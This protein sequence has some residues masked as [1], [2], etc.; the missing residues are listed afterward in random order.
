MGEGTAACAK[1]LGGQEGDA[2][3]LVTSHWC[4]PSIVTWCPWR[5]V[6]GQGLGCKGHWQPLS[7]GETCSRPRHGYSLKPGM[8]AHHVC[9]E[10][11]IRL[12]IWEQGDKWSAFASRRA[13]SQGRKDT[14][15]MG[16]D[17]K[18][19]VLKKHF[20]TEVKLSFGSPG[21]GLRHPRLSGLISGKPSVLCLSQVTLPWP[22]G[23]ALRRGTWAPP[24]EFSFKITLKGLAQS[25]ASSGTCI[26]FT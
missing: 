23:A 19:H 18:A 5:T 26:L 8:T 25:L 20:C 16:Q 11:S 9:M 21:E 17:H 12:R 4:N 6:P 22:E 7:Q 2:P 15:W 24:G 1:A 13:F 3:H 10:P 14:G